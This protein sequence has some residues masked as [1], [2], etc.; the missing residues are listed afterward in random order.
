MGDKVVV[1][2]RFLGTTPHSCYIHDVIRSICEQ[3]NFFYN[4]KK[5]ITSDNNLLMNQFK[6]IL[7]EKTGTIKI[8]LFF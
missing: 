5:N 7:N 1:V 2:T 4:L 6:E 8:I 3:I